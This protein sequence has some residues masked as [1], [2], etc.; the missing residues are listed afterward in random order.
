MWVDQNGR[1]S[2]FSESSHRIARG[3]LPSGGGVLPIAIETIGGAVCAR[4]DRL[5]VADVP[6]VAMGLVAL[7]FDAADWSNQCL[8][9]G[10]F[11][12]VLPPHRP[13][14]RV[15]GTHLGCIQ[16]NTSIESRSW[17]A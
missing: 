9:Y 5:R 10:V 11:F 7:D 1:N 8:L 15:T 16:Q 17:T 12:R 4:V 6:R 13:N 3:H 14:P 2:E